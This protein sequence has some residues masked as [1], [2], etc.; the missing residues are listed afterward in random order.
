MRRLGRQASDLADFRPS[1]LL[2]NTVALLDYEEI[3]QSSQGMREQDE[4]ALPVL[5]AIR[6]HAHLTKGQ[7]KCCAVAF[8]GGELELADDSLATDP[9]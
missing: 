2:N 6:E 4:I 7:L 1:L 3:D 9:C 5:R 8:A